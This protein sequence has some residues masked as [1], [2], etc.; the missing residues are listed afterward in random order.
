MSAV[1]IG[2][3]VDYGLH[4]A[5]SYREAPHRQPHKRVRDALTQTGISILAGSSVRNR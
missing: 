5:L 1:F 2:L 4:L 3:S